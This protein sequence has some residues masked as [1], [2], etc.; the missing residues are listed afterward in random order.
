MDFPT[1][2]IRIE[3]SGS[4]PQIEEEKI[5]QREE[6]KDKGRFLNVESMARVP[7]TVKGGR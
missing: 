2:V 7:V 5:I 6:C 3:I 4:K 1:G